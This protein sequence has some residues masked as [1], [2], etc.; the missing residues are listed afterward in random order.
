MALFRS[1]GL[2]ALRGLAGCRAEFWAFGPSLSSSPNRVLHSLVLKGSGD[3]QVNTLFFQ[4]KD[5]PLK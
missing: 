3:G 4:W 1:F 2:Q 5:L